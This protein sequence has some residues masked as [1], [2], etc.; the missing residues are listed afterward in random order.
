MSSSARAAAFQNR[1]R[2]EFFT[3]N[4]HVLKGYCY[5]P[6]GALLVLA[7]VTVGIW[8]PDWAS[9]HFFGLAAAAGSIAITAPW[10]WWMHRRYRS[11]YGHVR[12]SDSSGGGALGLWGDRSLPFWL[13]IGAL[14]ALMWW[15]VLLIHYIPQNT[16]LND[17]HFVFFF[18]SF[19]LLRGV[20]R[21]PSRRTQLVYGVALVPLV[22]VTLLPLVMSD[23][24]AI[25]IVNYAVFGLTAVGIG[26]YNHHLLVKT[27][28]QLTDTEVSTH[29]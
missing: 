6:A 23:L 19:P 27:F 18:A 9:V 13:V 1:H 14:V 5:V 17:N 11:S 28:G 26:L 3:T 24:W 21:P 8:R 16:A 25:Q 10:I 29:D 7:T 15:L 22:G 2:I 12:P 4:F 20:F